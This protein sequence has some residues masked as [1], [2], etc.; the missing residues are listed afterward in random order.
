[1]CDAPLHVALKIPKGDVYEWDVDPYMVS[2]AIKTIDLNLP[3][4]CTCIGEFELTLSTTATN[5]CY[6]VAVG[7]PSVLTLGG[8]YSHKLPASRATFANAALYFTLNEAPAAAPVITKQPVS[9]QA[10][11]GDYVGFLVETEGV[12]NAGHRWERSYDN[13]TTWVNY[14]VLEKTQDSTTLPAGADNENYGPNLRMGPIDETYDAQY[15]VIVFNSAGS[16]TSDVVT[17]T[18][19]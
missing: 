15:R 6:G 2:W 17:L 13:G 14:K 16:V 7:S 12:G 3:E 19:D 18:V 10:N 9:I 1:M 5:G 11:T 4:A 8:S